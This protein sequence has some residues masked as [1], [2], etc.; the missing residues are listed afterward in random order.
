MH[1]RAGV[2]LYRHVDGVAPLHRNPVGILVVGVRL[3]AQ[4]RDRPR[5][6]G[7]HIGEPPAL[8]VG[9]FAI[10]YVEVDR[11][12]RGMLVGEQTAEH[13]AGHLRR[14]VPFLVGDGVIPALAFDAETLDGLADC[15]AGDIAVATGQH[16]TDRARV[17][18]RPADVGAGIDARDDKVDR[19]E[20]AQPSEHH[21]QRRRARH[22]PRVLDA[23]EPHLVH[24]GLDEV[25]RPDRGTRARVLRIG[26]DHDDVAVCGHRAREHVQTLGLDS[27]IVGHQDAHRVEGTPRK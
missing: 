24:L 3:E 10:G 1:D 21:A 25:Q 26:S 19:P 22:R 27:V 15:Q 13:D 2:D 20:C 14:R 8:H 9:D 17:I 11:P 6:Q 12:R 5:R 7:A 18:H 16:R 4:R 23:L